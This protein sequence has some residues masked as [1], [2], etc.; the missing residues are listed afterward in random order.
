MGVRAV[1]GVRERWGGFGTRLAGNDERTE[2]FRASVAGSYAIRETLAL[3][4]ELLWEKQ[5]P[6]RRRLGGVDG[7]A[8]WG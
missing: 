8:Q 5:T 1:H 6:F 7:G 4:S 3:V 2:L